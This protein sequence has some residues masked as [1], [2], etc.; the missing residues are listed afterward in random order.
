[1]NQSDDEVDELSAILLGG[2]SENVSEDSDHNVI[3]PI[4]GG[5]DNGVGKNE[6]D[7]D[8]LEAVAGQHEGNTGGFNLIS[9]DWFFEFHVTG[10][11]H[12]LSFFHKGDNFNLELIILLVFLE[13][14]EFSINFWLDVLEG[15]GSTVVFLDCGLEGGQWVSG[16]GEHDQECEDDSFHF[17]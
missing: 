13:F 9:N 11:Q 2:V 1:M 14:G 6:D 5:L 10:F 17:N 8:I 15:L 3:D 4:F 16:E 7:S 12:F